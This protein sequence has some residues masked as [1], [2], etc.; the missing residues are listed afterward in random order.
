MCSS[1]LDFDP[2]EFDRFTRLQELTR[3][4]AESV[5]DVATV[6]RNLA[7]D[8]DEGEKALSMQR[9]ITREVRQDL[10][11]IRMI[12]LSSLSDR[13][14]RVARLSAKDNAKRV[15]MQIAGG[16]VEMDRGVIDRVAAPIEHLLRNAIV[17]G[18]EAP[19]VRVAAGKREAGTLKLTARQEGNEIVLT[20]ADDGA[21][22]NIARIREKAIA[23]GLMR[24]NERLT[25]QQIANFIFRSGF[26]TAGAWARRFRWAREHP[27]PFICR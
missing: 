18:I 23:L 21:G 26:S 7:R 10:M 15:D 22:L 13:L 19:A 20:L 24:E 6:Q 5:N 27:S 25:D 3:L 9:Q 16:Q 4:M 17:H 12:P 1:D 14:H 8:L 2:L 11:A